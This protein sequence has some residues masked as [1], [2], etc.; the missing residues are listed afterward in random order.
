MQRGGD[1]GGRRE[2]CQRM[3]EKKKQAVKEKK[4]YRDRERDGKQETE[5]EQEKERE[6][7]RG[8]TCIGVESEGCDTG[9]LIIS[10]G[11]GISQQASGPPCYCPA[12]PGAPPFTQEKKRK[13]IT[14][15]NSW[16]HTSP[17]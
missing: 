14:K 5:K 8:R 16:P 12:S 3:R 7:E 10:K 15:Q 1:S 13:Q 11:A 6:R 17:P 2:R 9:V 4:I